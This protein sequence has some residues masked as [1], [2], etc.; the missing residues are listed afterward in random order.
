MLILLVVIAVLAVLVI[1]L[2]A[3]GRLAGTLGA[4]APTAIYDLDEAVVYV[5]DRLPDE[6]TASLSYDDVRSLLMW[7]LEY[8]EE[9]GVARRQ[10]VD[11]IESGPLLASEDIALAWVLG[12]ATEASLEF[13]DVWVAQVLVANEKYLDAIGAIG[14]IAGPSDE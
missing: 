9:S 13:D 14:E 2:V 1:A 4:Q 6:V 11:E 10:G 7:H 5:A 8:L 12:R 3:V